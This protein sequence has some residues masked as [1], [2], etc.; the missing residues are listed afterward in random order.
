MPQSSGKEPMKKEHVQIQSAGNLESEM[1]VV[2]S[3]DGFRNRT[4]ISRHW[5]V[6]CFQLL[7]ADIEVLACMLADI[8]LGISDCQHE[9]WSLAEHWQLFQPASVTTQVKRAG[10]FLIPY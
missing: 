2:L 9:I 4:N 6:L 8:T 10:K 5:S 1:T 7:R 3:A